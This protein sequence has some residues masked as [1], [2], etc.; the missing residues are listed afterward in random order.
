MTQNIPSPSRRYTRVRLCFV[1]S[2][3]RLWNVGFIDNADRTH[4]NVFTPLVSGLNRLV[5]PLRTRVPVA[6]VSLMEHRNV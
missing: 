4:H 2:S 3:V 6:H 1:F 5:V